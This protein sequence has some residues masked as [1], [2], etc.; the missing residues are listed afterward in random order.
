[1]DCIVNDPVKYLAMSQKYK[2]GTS[3]SVMPPYDDD[4]SSRGSRSALMFPPTPE[5]DNANGGLL[6]STC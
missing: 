5:A 1:M 2:R 6:L 4:L 3:Q